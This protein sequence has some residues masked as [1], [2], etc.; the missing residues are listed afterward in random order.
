MTETKTRRQTVNFL[1]FLRGQLNGLQGIPTLCFELIQNAD[2]VK[3][4]DGNPGASIITFDVCE[5]ALYVYND[6]VFREIDYERMEKVSWGNKREEAGTTGAFGLGFISVYQIT[7]SPE[8]FSSGRHWQ[9]R[10]NGHED[11]RIIE[12]LMETKETKFRLPWAFE[13]SEVRKELGILPVRRDSLEETVRQINKA[14]ESA[15]LF[16]KQVTTLELKR[17]GRL[18]RK[19]ET[20]RE[21]DKLLLVDGN[22]TV[23]WRILEGEFEDAAISMR[24]K[25]GEIIEQKRQPLVKL[26]VPDHPD[27]NGLLYA[28]L[29]SETSTGLPFHINADFYPTQDRKRIIFD[30]SY[31]S[32]WN[33]TAIECAAE[34]LAHHCGEILKLFSNQE[35]WEFAERVKDASEDHGL[36]SCFSKFWELL[37]PEIKNRLAVLTSS[38]RLVFPSDAIFLDTKE[39]TNAGEIFKNL[40]MKTV[41]PDLRGRRNILLETG[42]HSIRL[43]D[44]CSVFFEKELTQRT[45]LSSMP[46]G[47]RSLEGWKTL[48][49]AFADLWNRSHFNE[50][51]E[52]R[53]LLEGIAIALGSDGALWPPEELFVAESKARDFF[54]KISQVVW[55]E[56]KSESESF[57]ADF[58]PAFGIEDGLQL[59]EEA[60]DALPALWEEGVYF[61]DEMLEWLEE[62]RTELDY[63]RVQKFKALAIWPSAEG[64][65]KPLNDLYLTGDFEDPLRLAQ[66]VDLDALG[67]GRDFLERVLKVPQLDFITYVREWVPSVVRNRQLKA[68]D[69]L[70]L[71]KILAENL[72][73][74]REHKDIA[75]TLS[76]L[77]IVWCGAEDFFPAAMVWFDTKEV[78][79]LLGPEIKIAKLPEE[80]S[81]AVRELY[82]WI[83]VS[84]EPTPKDIVNRIRRIVE[85]PPDSVKVRLLGRLIEFISTKWTLWDDAEKEQFAVLKRINWL[86]G[87]KDATR[88]FNPRDIYSIFRFYLFESQG[89]FLNIDNGIQRKA[90][91]FLEY[92]GIKSEPQANQVVR[93][94]LFLSQHE[95]PVTQEIYVFLN[96][97]CDDASIN[98][99]REQ[100]CLFMK[101][102]DGNET[103]FKPNQ[104]FWEQHAF[105]KY[106]YRLSRD[107][108][109]FKNLFEKIGVKEKPDMEDTINVLLEISQEFGESNK[110]LTSN[111]EE[112]EI[113]IMCWKLISGALE[114]E[115]F[116][117][118]EIK[119]RLGKQKTIPDA[120]KLLTK[121]ELMFFE[122]RV[123]WG[124]KFKV[125]KNNLISRIEGAWLGMEAA[126][127]RPLSSVV[128]TE[129]VTCENRTEDQTLLALIKE[130][131]NLILRVIE[132]HRSKEIKALSVQE[133]EKLTFFSADR[134]DLVRIF[135]GFGTKEESDLES[136]DAIMLDGSLYFSMQDGNYPW[137]GIAR[138]LSF[139]I[140]PTGELRSL[141]MELKEILSLSLKEA[142]N[143]LDELGYPMVEEKEVTGGVGSTLE[144]EKEEDIEGIRVPVPGIEGTE[145]KDKIGSPGKGSGSGDPTG[146]PTHKP[147][148][149]PDGRVKAKRKNSRLRSYVYPENEVSTRQEDP[150]LAEKRTRVGEQGVE[151]V[152]QYE[153]E[154]G[155]EPKDMETVQVHHP[156][157]DIEST[158]ENGK[159]R[160]I[161]VKA[162]SGTWD[163]QNPAQL[164]KT[165]FETAKKKGETY[166][167]YIVER[168]ESDDYEIQMIQNPANRVE[169]YLY[170]HGW[171]PEEELKDYI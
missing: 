19:I 1:G 88:W 73:K 37:K 163:S 52:S 85:N 29:P 146:A 72:G 151:K 75:A 55:Y 70:K 84:P 136:V 124:E 23:V 106:R 167:L 6:G 53:E 117:A 8:I 32:D 80:K 49:E 12:T 149:Q 135:S 66:L 170:D 171:I 54:S 28:F 81:E 46:K 77:S 58:V 97:N 30:E 83:G 4:E 102:P 100:K 60:E 33:E 36:S 86:P 15:A 69:K 112:E 27:L 35:F 144:Y 125:V 96:Q 41:H 109:R 152:M 62:N 3:D 38:D 118:G 147:G 92:L 2:D 114:K 128:G 22:Q 141:G 74:L 95:K 133:L 42:T 65:L 13:A 153:R 119:K 11:E 116:S 137:K 99:L 20:I 148:S 157:Y 113:L 145:E 165:E 159:I 56:E 154:E 127:V 111:P 68:D 134:I 7:D 43:E 61:P 48:W 93:H 90:S 17:E 166:W 89:N 103:F 105:G 164:T 24:R 79:E 67:G 26:A 126:G 76:G 142:T 140:N 108:G 44:I 47:L 139:V 18:V 132:V 156:G 130:R 14:I 131:K 21:G 87:S 59:L 40:G 129:L 122:D 78:R 10:P 120:R 121:P 34:T 16:L 50:R 64:E 25:Y 57:P 160:Y 104:V 138:E 39:L 143:T 168:A 162:L 155:R 110:V 94:L 123:G 71:I 31:K 107:Y 63:Y 98:R 169:Y 51:Q 161:E 91:A 101:N 5:D 158:D 45:Q 9:F 82:L 150:S 115:N